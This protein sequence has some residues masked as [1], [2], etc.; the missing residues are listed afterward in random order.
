MEEREDTAVPS[1]VRR[2]VT[3][4]TERSAYCRTDIGEERDATGGRHGQG[5]LV[6]YARASRRA[7]GSQRETK[8]SQGD[9]VLPSLETSRNA[10]ERK[11]QGTKRDHEDSY[12]FG[13]QGSKRLDTIGKPMGDVLEDLT[14]ASLDKIEKYVKPVAQEPEG[15]PAPA[16]G[17]VRTLEEARQRGDWLFIFEAARETHLDMGAE[18][19]LVLRFEKRKQEE[20]YLSK[21][22]HVSGDFNRWIT[23]FEDQVKVCETIGVVLTEETKVFYFMNNLNDTIFGTVKANFMELSIRVQFPDTYDE[24]KQRVIS[25][26]GQITSR[27][28]Q[29][30]LKV[31]KG[32]DA[33]RYGEA[34]FKAEEEGCHVC[35]VPRHVYLLEN[36]GL[37]VVVV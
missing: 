33:K 8:G 10:R 13:D 26:Y 17:P 12:R 7:G 28:P 16:P 32:E 4:W 1:E 15:A 5:V 22:K 2:G 18:D 9:G 3:H 14:K 29:T 11:A 24:I 6:T 34:S 30:V 27:K 23:R 20:D 25:E 19:D 31:I 36:Q 35:G 21:L 37:V